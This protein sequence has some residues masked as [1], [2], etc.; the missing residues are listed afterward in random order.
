M[1]KFDNFG[2]GAQRA[3]RIGFAGPLRRYLETD[4][5]L[6]RVDPDTGVPRRDPRTGFCVRAAYG[7]AGEAIGKIKNM[8]V[9]TEYLRDPEATQEKVLRDVFVKGDAWQKMGDLIVH[10]RDGWVRFHDRMGDTFRWKGENVSAGE[11]RDHLGVLEEVEDA[12]VYGV[13]LAG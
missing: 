10:D 1:A 13:K 4:T 6:I 12:V 11:V 3:G 8:A 5:F 2:F 7:E 9:L